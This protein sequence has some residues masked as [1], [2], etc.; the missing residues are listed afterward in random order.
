MKMTA[1]LLALP[2]SGLL[3]GCSHKDVVKSDELSGS[4]MTSMIEPRGIPK[5]SPAPVSVVLK[6]SVFK[7]NGDYANNVA[8]AVDGNGKL[9][10]FPDPSDIN[11]SSCPVEVGD[12]WWLNRQGIGKG[13]KF[14]R[15]TFEEYSRLE[16]V[17]TVTELLDA[18]IPGA[19]VTELR[20]FDIPASEAMDRLTEIK[21]LLGVR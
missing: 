12:G 8:V 1:V 11:Q 14:T 15:Y 10:Y 4:A 7:M 3:F 5:K 16:K 18:I 17:P 19:E 2:L 21:S 20:T 13:Y 6:A 9:T